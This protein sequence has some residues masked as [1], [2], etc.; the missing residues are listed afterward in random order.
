MFTKE[1]I[2]DRWAQKRSEGVKPDIH[3]ALTIANSS[4]FDKKTR[5]GRPYILHPLIVGFD[6]T[7][8]PNKQIIGVLHDVVEDTNWTLD[9]LRGLGFSKKIITGIDGITKREGEKYLDFIVRCGLAGEYAIDIKLNDLDHN[10]KKN[11]SQEI[12]FSEKNVSKEK[13]YN[14]SYFY[15]VAIKQGKIE[16]GTSI[17]EYLKKEPKYVSKP[18]TANELLDMF[19]SETDR[20]A[21]SPLADNVSA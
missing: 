16:P 1:E 3:L 4:L 19:S 15:L 17:L 18:A 10:T 6:N 5:D 8:S 9:D 14:I 20:L 21:T 13:V 12:V 2:I 7:K 11:R